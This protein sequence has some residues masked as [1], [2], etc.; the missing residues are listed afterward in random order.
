MLAKDLKKGRGAASVLKGWT[1]E[2]ADAESGRTQRDH[3]LLPLPQV[4][5][6]E[7]LPANAGDIR[8]TGSI[9]GSG[10]SPGGGHGDPLQYSCLEKPRD[11]G[12]A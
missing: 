6:G 5:P 10:R 8:D 4:F 3:R 11:R 7:N 12:G 9:P 2:Q 1:S